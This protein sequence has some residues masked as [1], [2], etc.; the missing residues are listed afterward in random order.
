LK[1]DEMHMR[2]RF[3]VDFNTNQVIGIS[4]DAFDKSLIEQELN[5][6]ISLDRDRE[7]VDE[8]SVPQPNKKFLVFVDTLLDTDQPKQQIVV[9]GYGLRNPSAEFIAHR[10]RE[11]PA[12]LY[13]HGFIVKHI[14]CDGATEIRSALHLVENVTAWDVL[15]DVFTPGELSGLSTGFMVGYRHPSQGCEDITIFFGGDMPRHWVK[16]LEM[17]SIISRG[18]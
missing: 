16:K 17:H 18:S 15:S 8:V 9:A 12:A 13:D 14:G 2:G 1:L 6:L 10:L 5:E 3:G 11:L 7:A 4:A